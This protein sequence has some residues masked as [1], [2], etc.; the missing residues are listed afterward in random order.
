[1]DS[2]TVGVSALSPSPAAN[3]MKMTTAASGEGFE[4]DGMVFTVTESN[5]VAEV[6]DGGAVHALG[7]ES[8]FDAGTGTQQHFVDV[9][10]KTEA[11]LLLVSVN[12]DQRR[13][14]GVRRFC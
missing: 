13:I 9:Q 14:V 4:F 8:F 5:E 6:V 3:E 11:M 12:E 1:M 10:G 7:S 2:S